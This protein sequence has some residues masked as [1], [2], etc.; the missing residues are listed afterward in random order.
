MLADN[1]RNLHVTMARQGAEV[2]AVGLQPDVGQARQMLEA[3]GM[4]GGEQALLEEI[5]QRR[6]AGHRPRQVGVVYP[7]TRRLRAASQGCET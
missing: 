2:D 4:L 3:D 1:W 5:Y 7:A 6:S